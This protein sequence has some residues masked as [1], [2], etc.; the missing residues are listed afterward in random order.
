[1][2]LVELTANVLITVVSVLTERQI[3]RVRFAPSCNIAATGLEIEVSGDLGELV[4]VGG[5]DTG[6]VAHH[7]VGVL[8]GLGIGIVDIRAEA[9]GVQV[10]ILH[11]LRTEGILDRHSVHGAVAASRLGVE[12]ISADRA[13]RKVPAVPRRANHQGR[14][15]KSVRLD[16]VGPAGIYLT[17]S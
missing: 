11:V 8:A 15:L 5:T 14:V 17:R 9:V 12:G 16:L 2:I 4:E 13:A 1:M 6:L 10:H 3:H 7:V